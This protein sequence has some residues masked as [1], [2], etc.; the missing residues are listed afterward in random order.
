MKLSYFMYITGINKAHY[1]SPTLLDRNSI[2]EI[3]GSRYMKSPISTTIKGLIQECY[4][5]KPLKIII[6]KRVHFHESNESRLMLR[7]VVGH[8]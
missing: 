4:P 8:L 2:I 6:F 7:I 5:N 3:A 1:R